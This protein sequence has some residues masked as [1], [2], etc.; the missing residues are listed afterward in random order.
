MTTTWICSNC[1]STVTESEVCNSSYD[2]TDHREVSLCDHCPKDIKHPSDG[3]DWYDY[4]Q[5]V[6]S[7]PFDTEPLMF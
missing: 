1:G 4:D 7:D 2:G 6:D 3:Y 5:S